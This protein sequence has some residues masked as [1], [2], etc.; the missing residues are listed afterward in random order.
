MI[1]RCVLFVQLENLFNMNESYDVEIG[2]CD[3]ECDLQIKQFCITFL[4]VGNITILHN[5]SVSTTDI[6]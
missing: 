4:Q 6:T 5:R 2:E 1:L 3:Y